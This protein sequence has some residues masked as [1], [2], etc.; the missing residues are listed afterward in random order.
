MRKLSSSKEEAQKFL[1]LDET[2]DVSNESAL[3]NIP[4]IHSVSKKDQKTLVNCG[5]GQFKST[6]PT[7]FFID[8]S[9]QS[10]H[11]HIILIGSNN[12]NNPYIKQ[13]EQDV[14]T[15]TDMLLILYYN[16][17]DETK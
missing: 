12:F 9:L 10:T 4:L 13:L 17:R 15:I 7:M 14:C 1:A 6:T 2:P 3:D 5:R 11:Q 16:I 8:V